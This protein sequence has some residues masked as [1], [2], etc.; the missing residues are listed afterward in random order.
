MTQLSCDPSTP[1]NQCANNPGA[2]NVFPGT[3]AM[4]ISGDPVS[5]PE[6]SSLILLGTGLLSILGRRVTPDDGLEVSLNSGPCLRDRPGALLHT[7]AAPLSHRQ[8]RS[9]SPI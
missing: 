8:A 5:T 2:Y 7:E 4:Q 1:S 3:Y 6:P 9:F